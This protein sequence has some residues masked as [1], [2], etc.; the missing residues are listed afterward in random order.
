MSRG[1]C[2]RSNRNCRRPARPRPAALCRRLPNEP[3]RSPLVQLAAA[4]RRAGTGG[5]RRRERYRRASRRRVTETV[6]GELVTR[7]RPIASPQGELLA[8]AEP[9]A[10]QVIRATTELGVVANWYL[11][12]QREDVVQIRYQP[13]AQAPRDQTSLSEQTQDGQSL[14]LSDRKNSQLNRL[15]TIAADGDRA[16]GVSS[17]RDL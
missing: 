14:N 6:R 4:R 13:L 2:A 9:G 1:K 11:E 17:S 7:L 8:E 10:S 15:A 3:G 12:P 16:R 5:R